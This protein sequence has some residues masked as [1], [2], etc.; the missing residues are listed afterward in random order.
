MSPWEGLTSPTWALPI[1]A[2]R[3]MVGLLGAAYFARTWRE[4]PLFSGP[5]GLV[6][7]GLV[8]RILPFTR[9]CLFPPRASLGTL[10]TLHAVGMVASLRRHL[11]GTR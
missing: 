6:D 1:D 2:F 3:A 8:R 7:H 9:L 11:A 10:R 4:A 5:D